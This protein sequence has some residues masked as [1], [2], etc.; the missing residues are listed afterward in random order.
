MDSV[1]LHL[2]RSVWR[3]RGRTSAALSLLLL[4]KIAAV[5]VPCRWR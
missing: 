2:W 3:H 1:L 5:L 4:A